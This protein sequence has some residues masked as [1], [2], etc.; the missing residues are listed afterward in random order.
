MSNIGVLISQF[1]T[2]GFT[3]NF[4]E[5][6]V[7]DDRSTDGTKE[8]VR[9][10]QHRNSDITLVTTPLRLGLARSI[11]LGI[12]QA[13]FD[14]VLVMDTDGMHDPAYL[15]IMLE[16]YSTEGELIIGSRHAPGG[17][18]EGMVYPHFSK[19]M[20]I[21]IR[22][23]VKSQIRDQLC[24]YFLANKKILLKMGESYFTGFGEYFISVIAFYEENSKKIVELPTIHHAR[25]TGQRKSKR[26]KMLVTYLRT[27]FYV[28]KV[29]KRRSLSL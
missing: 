11:Y 20:N 28:R 14:S 16:K 10:M 7:I 27:A 4:L 9:E 15:S 22:R 19:M 3:R 26:L 8:L 23:I 24:G 25:N 6:L 18:M 2:L 29:K 21:I 5:L 1:Y 13:K 12:S 17:V